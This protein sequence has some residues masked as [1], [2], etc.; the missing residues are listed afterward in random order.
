MKKTLRLFLCLSALTFAAAAQ[1]DEV[2]IL[3]NSSSGDWE[4][5]T[6][7][8]AGYAA[9]ISGFTISYYLGGTSSPV[10]PSSDH[11]R[12]YKSNYLL[13]EGENNEEITKVVLN[14]VSSSYCVDITVNGSETGTADTDELTVTWEGSTESFLA[15]MTTAQVRV[16]SI[17][18]TYGEG[19]TYNVATPVISPEGGTYTEAQT[20]TITCETDGASIYYTTDGTTPTAESTLYSEALTI[21]E[22]CT[23][24]AIAYV[25]DEASRVATATYLFAPSTTGDGTADNPYT[26]ADALAIIEAGTYTSDDVYVSG[27]VSTIS[28]ISTSYGNATYFISDDGTTDSELEIYRGYY[29]DGAKFTSED[30]LQ[31][32]DVVVVC[33]ELTLYYTTP[34]VTT[35]SSIISLTRDGESIEPDEDDDTD[36]DGGTSDDP[37]TV[38]E[39][40]AIIEAGTYTSDNVYVKGI[41][42]SISEISTSYGNAT[43]FIS[44]DG[45]TDSELEIY[46]GYYLDG[47]KFTSEDDLQVGDVVV[48]CGELTLYY[49]TPE[50]TSGSSIISLT[51]DGESIESED[52]DETDA[53]GGTA[54]DPYTVAEALAIIEAGTYTSD[55]VYVK[56]IV[57]TISEISTSYGNATYFISDDGSTD[58]ELEIYRGYYLDGAKFTSSDDLQTGDTVI[59]YGVLTLYYSTAEVTTGSSITYLGR[60]E[61]TDNDEE[62]STA[63]YNVYAKTSELAAGSYLIVVQ[64]GTNTL[65]ATTPSSSYTYAYLYTN[66]VSGLVDTISIDASY[67]YAYTLTASTTTDGAYTIQDSYGRYLYQN[68]TYTSYQLSSTNN[69]YDWNI[70]LNDDGTWTI[71]YASSGYYAQYSTTYSSFGCYSSAQSGALMPYLYALVGTTAEEDTDDGDTDD[72][73]TDTTTGETFTLVTDAST[74]A[75]GDVITFANASYGYSIAEQNENNRNFL[76]VEVTI[77]DGVL[78]AAETTSTFTLSTAD[79]G[80]W[81]IQYDETG[82]YLTS[83]SASS[84]YLSTQ[85][86]AD[87]LYSEVTIDIAEDG[88][89]TIVFQGDNEKRWMRY[90]ANGYFS[91]YAEGSQQDLQIYR[92]D[93]T[94]TGIDSLTATETTAVKGIY[95]LSGMRLSTLDGAAAGIYIVDGAKILVK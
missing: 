78:T 12:C 53:D 42:S 33:G 72:D 43:Y 86:E 47:A 79:D 44:D 56:G 5:I 20:V 69:G 34:E 13:I 73:D 24:S 63:T 94:D 67:D 49:S 7:P 89:A 31:V 2:N 15:Q 32:G 93:A 65:Y 9:T 88:T 90:N 11:I 58:S 80:N 28:E 70:T 6:E 54:D 52:D 66:T 35:G 50:V 19:T 62:E 8:A 4:A 83:N 23:L 55:N 57:S 68:G 46:R 77:E 18:I 60:P 84:N 16:T 26:V 40:L 59:V 92:K 75:A 87:G 48:I 17:D 21:S 81:L 41:V 25:D 22:A 14:C 27:I 10:A 61:S 38:A 3:T 91:V 45:S 82:Y 74:L 37:Y 85:E 64:D 39:A 29:L 1:A 95:T 76:T 36:T 71:S 30:D 51:R